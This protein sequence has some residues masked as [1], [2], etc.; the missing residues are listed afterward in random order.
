ME[1]DKDKVDEMVLALLFL[2]T[3]EDH[4]QL[5]AWKGM[6]WGA[7]DRLFEKGY[8]YDPKSKA[9]SVAL[10]DEGAKRSEE[11]FRKHFGEVE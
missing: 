10:T 6:D 11:L 8:I 2:T 7:M 4:R 3:F 1:Y 9:K 5:R